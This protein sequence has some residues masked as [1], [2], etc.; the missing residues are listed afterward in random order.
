MPILTSKWFF[1]YTERF[2]PPGHSDPSSHKST[3]PSPAPSL[4]IPI[5]SNILNEVEDARDFSTLRPL[6]N[7]VGEFD[8]QERNFKKRKSSEDVGGKGRAGLMN[9]EVVTEYPSG[10]TNAAPRHET[11][12]KK[13]SCFKETNDTDEHSNRRGYERH[14]KAKLIQWMNEYFAL[15][16]TVSVQS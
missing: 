16:F 15:N 8:G 5:K 7:P 3:S 10:G 11:D 4:A 12:C 1:Y 13:G 14:V 9:L 2:F 6:I